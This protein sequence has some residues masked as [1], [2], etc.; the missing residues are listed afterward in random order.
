MAIL[1]TGGCGYIGSH[2]L[3]SLLNQDEKVIVVDDLS[4]SSM[5]S[6]ERVRYI[7]NKDFVFCEGNILDEMFISDV[8]AKYEIKS[9]MHFAAKKSVLESTQ[10]PVEYY[11]N[12]VSG[13]LSI[14]NAI[15]KYNVN[16]FVFSSSA[17]VYGEPETIPLSEEN[18]IGGTTNPYGT[19]KYMVEQILRDVSYAYPQKKIVSLR[20]FNP[21]GAHPSG[22]IGEDPRGISSN[23]FP[24][25]TQVAIGKREFLNVFGNDYNTYDGSGVRDYIHVMDLAEGHLA[26]LNFLRNNKGYY[27]F[28]LGT[29][30]GYSVLDVVNKFKNVTQRD[31]PVKFC[32]RRKGDVAEC[33][34]SPAKANKYLSWH[35]KR[36]LSEM[37]QDAWNWQL[38]NPDGYR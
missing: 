20:Y 27:C 37:V 13:T 23:L 38:N 28:N 30:V 8:F 6:L 16:D 17:T 33:W 36:S 12:N 19:S 32:P 11:L 22:L 10:I 7:T 2:T 5:I 3:I 26:A 34:S 35:A 15:I 18:K 1:L 9:V 29:G 24:Y 21:V 25:I 31:I 14:L 4:N